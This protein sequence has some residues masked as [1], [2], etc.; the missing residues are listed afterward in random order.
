MGLR[1]N[2]LVKMKGGRNNLAATSRETLIPSLVTGSGAL[3]NLA[4]RHSAGPD[5]STGREGSISR[6]GVSP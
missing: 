2:E 5:F 6:K 4:E 3:D 1:V